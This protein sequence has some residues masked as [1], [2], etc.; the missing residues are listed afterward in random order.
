MVTSMCDFI[1]TESCE[2][3]HFAYAKTR[4]QS[5]RAAD[6]RL[7]FR[8]TDS[9]ITALNKSEISRLLKI[10]IFCGFTVW[11]VSDL[12]GNPEDLFSHG[13]SMF[14][15]MLCAEK[16]RLLACRICYKAIQ[17]PVTNVSMPKLGSCRPIP[18]VFQQYS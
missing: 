6:Q 16:L 12:I 7:C 18:C 9:V 15:E 8:Y 1:W 10:A 2:N 3:L 14:L 4:T 17:A 5:N 11:F 13:A